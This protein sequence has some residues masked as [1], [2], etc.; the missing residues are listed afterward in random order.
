MIAA[1]LRFLARDPVEMPA[2]YF[3]QMHASYRLHRMAGYREGEAAWRSLWP[4]GRK[5]RLTVPR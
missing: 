1:F 5:V 4:F 3:W 2:A